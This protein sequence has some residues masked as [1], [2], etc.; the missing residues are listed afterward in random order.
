[1]SRKDLISLK[2]D[3]SNNQFSEDVRKSETTVLADVAVV[4]FVTKAVI[5][6]FQ[7]PIVTKDTCR[8]VVMVTNGLM[9][10]MVRRKRQK[11]CLTCSVP[12]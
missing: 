1:M 8:F 2:Q 12:S 3:K 6:C 5:R 4:A 9:V 7:I 11:H 10:A